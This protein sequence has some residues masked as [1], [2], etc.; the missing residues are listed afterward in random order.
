MY[1]VTV[2]KAKPLDS[3]VKWYLPGICQKRKV[4]PCVHCPHQLAINLEKFSLVSTAFFRSKTL[5]IVGSPTPHAAHPFRDRGPVETT[6]PLANVHIKPISN[7]L[8]DR[9]QCVI[10]N[11]KLTL[12][13]G[14][15]PESKARRP[16]HQAWF[17]D[18]SFD[19]TLQ[20][21]KPT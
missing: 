3:F 20:E 21:K 1:E 16:Q 18:D 17:L 7:V 6:F 13:V 5:R 14:G 2:D 11:Q 8:F 15:S 10:I 4:V 19:E 9:L 12:K